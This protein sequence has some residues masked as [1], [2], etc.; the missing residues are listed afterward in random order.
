M[1]LLQTP[2]LYCHG[3]MR[4]L[5]FKFTMSNVDGYT[6]NMHIGYLNCPECPDAQVSVS[7]SLVS[8]GSRF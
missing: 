3:F 8:G 4:N 6:I 1:S 5:Q 7:G 2:S